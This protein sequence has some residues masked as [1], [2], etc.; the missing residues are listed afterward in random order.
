MN[1]LLVCVAFVICSLSSIGQE[2]KITRKVVQ[3]FP[4]QCFYLNGGIR[5]EFGGKSRVY[6]RIDLPPHTVGWVYSFTTSVNPQSRA[7]LKLAA[8]MTKLIDPTGMTALATEAILAPTGVAKADIYLCDKQ[9]IELFMQKVDNSGGTYRYFESGSRLNFTHGVVPVKDI[10]QG[11]YYLG[12]KNPS[13]TD[14]INVS[15]EVAAVVEERTLVEKTEGETK[16]ELY[17]KTGWNAYSQGDYNKCMELSKKALEFEPDCAP[18]KCNIALCCLVL[19]RTDY[20][21]SYIDAVATCKK[22]T[23]PK[24]YLQAALQDIYDAQR[25][26]TLTNAGEIITLLKQE[27]GA[28]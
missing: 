7:N 23:N 17:V 6:Y 9:N 15:L 10:R 14:G 11:M 24:G 1:R 19:N 13:S 8:Q 16:A 27:I 26:M 18:A 21:D 5:A 25:K 22:S 12:V 2:Y 20:M 3:I 28:R 4:E